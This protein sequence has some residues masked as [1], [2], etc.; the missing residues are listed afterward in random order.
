MAPNTGFQAFVGPIHAIAPLWASTHHKLVLWPYSF[1]WGRATSDLQQ[2]SSQRDGD[3][4]RSIVRP[5]FVQ[6]VLDVKVNR[7]L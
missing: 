5:E 3:R 6:Q 7:I 2:S 1:W 4:M